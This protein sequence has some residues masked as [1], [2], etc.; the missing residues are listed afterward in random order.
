MWCFKQKT[1]R[2]INANHKQGVYSL[3][4]AI[5]SKHDWLCQAAMHPGN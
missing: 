3:E 1:L 2:Y 4:A 5:N